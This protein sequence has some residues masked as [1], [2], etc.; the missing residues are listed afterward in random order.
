MC[1]WAC[2]EAGKWYPEG[3]G[4]IR[5]KVLCNKYKRCRKDIKRQICEMAEGQKS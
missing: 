2:G 4:L 3:R 5:R 1:V